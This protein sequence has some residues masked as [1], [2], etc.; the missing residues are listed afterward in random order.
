MIASAATRP[1]TDEYIPYYGRYIS[2]VPEDDAIEALERPLGDMIPFL[3]GLTDTQGALRYAPG[4]WSI[5]QVVG[6]VIDVERVFAYRA[7]RIARADRTPLPG[8]DEVVFA[9][10]AASDRLP[11]RALAD[12]LE[13]LRRAN[14]AMFR[15]LPEEAWTRRGTANDAPISVR[16]LAYVIAGH[17]RHHANLVRERYLSA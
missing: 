9:D 17:G 14:V 2:L 12:E 4:K 1:T 6:H 7:L 5:K 16:A 13:L 11:L 10:H 15:G 3:G 8:F